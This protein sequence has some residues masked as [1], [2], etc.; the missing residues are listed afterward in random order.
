MQFILIAYDGTDPGAPARRIKVR[1]LHLEGARKLKKSGN[2]IWGGAL[3]DENQN[4]KGS[5]VVYEYESREELDDMLREEPYITGN[6]WQRIDI[7][8]FKLANI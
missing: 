8:I 1:E 3:L 5:V 7:Q 6:V 4:M 2:L